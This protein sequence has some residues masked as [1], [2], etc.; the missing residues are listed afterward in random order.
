MPHFIPYSLG[1]MTSYSSI[2]LIKS[3]PVNSYIAFVAQEI[4]Y[5]CDSSKYEC[6]EIARYARSED[7]LR[8]YGPNYWFQWLDKT[9]F[10][11]GS[12]N[13]AVF[14][15]N[16]DDNM[17]IEEP[18]VHDLNMPITATFSA[19]GYLAICQSNSTILFYDRDIKQISSLDFEKGIARFKCV[20]FIYPRTLTAIFS[21]SPFVAFLDENAI[22]HKS[23]FLFKFEDEKHAV[24]TSFCAYK[25]ILAYSVE[26]NS[27][28][29][30]QLNDPSSKA[31]KVLEPTPVRVVKLEWSRNG[32]TLFIMLSNSTIML[33]ISNTGNVCTVRCKEIEGIMDAEFDSLYQQIFY[34]K[35]D[36]TGVIYIGETNNTVLFTPDQ[37]FSLYQQ[38]TLATIQELPKEIFPIRFGIT[39]LDQYFVIA[40][41]NGFIFINNKTN[42]IS[43]FNAIPVKNIGFIGR[44]IVVFTQRHDDW[45]EASVFDFNCEQVTDFQINHIPLYISTRKDYMI[46][47][48][49]EFATDIKITDSE[50]PIKLGDRY[51]SLEKHQIPPNTT[52]CLLTGENQVVITNNKKESSFLTGQPIKQGVRYCWNNSCPDITII[53]RSKNFI[54]IYKG[55][56]FKF[57]GALFYND[58]ARTFFLPSIW[59]LGKL[60]PIFRYFTSYFMIEMSHDPTIFR[61]FADFYRGMLCLPDVFSHTILLSFVKE[62]VSEICAKILDVLTDKEISDVI[63]AT[64]RKLKLTD[65]FEF[66]KNRVIPWRRAF[67]EYTAPTKRDIVV[68]VHPNDLKHFL[69]DISPIENVQDLI[70]EII[71]LGALIP[72]YFVAAQEKIELLIKSEIDTAKIARF[73]GIDKSRYSPED[74]NTCLDELEKIAA[75]SQN[76]KLL[77]AVCINKDRS[78]A[79]EIEKSHPELHEDFQKAKE[80]VIGKN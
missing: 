22:L 18:K 76:I 56:C 63:L 5:I 37:V 59:D 36:G 13:G 4:L 52:N 72:A 48:C 19:F 1:K 28:F 27:V 29:V 33:Y 35:F 68:A 16:F 50:T 42:T 11:W 23:P 21:G 74:F 30:K 7:S 79:E 32:S 15:S 75:K 17:K 49:Q 43:K 67:K 64:W 70:S 2:F 66:A 58:C 53:Q 65:K 61:Q 55:K 78:K 8:A 45:Y 46:V 6:P 10:V 73:I 54:M 40:N 12:C 24:L 25:N 47:G 34:T 41:S 3:N 31:V 51:L 38:K 14:V 26:N 62:N 9:T 39:L 44:Y 20:K 69:E 60:Q 80:S 57:P 77:Y 71:D